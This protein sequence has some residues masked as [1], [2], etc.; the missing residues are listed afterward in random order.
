[1]SQCNFATGKNSKNP[2]KN[3]TG[4]LDTYTVCV[5]VVYVCRHGKHKQETTQYAVT[6]DFR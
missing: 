1:M 6:H 3:Q 4:D 5:A 2:P